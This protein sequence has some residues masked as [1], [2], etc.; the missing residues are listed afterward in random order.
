MT[1]ADSIFIVERMDKQS[2]VIFNARR[3][4]VNAFVA[5]AHFGHIVSCVDSQLRRRVVFK[6]SKHQ[7]NHHIKTLFAQ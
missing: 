5:T 4:P 3:P 2:S 7:V 1:F 6:I